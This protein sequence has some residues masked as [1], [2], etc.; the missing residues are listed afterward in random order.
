MITIYIILITIIYS[1]NICI[2]TDNQP[3]VYGATCLDIL[4]LVLQDSAY[5]YKIIY[6]IMNAVKWKL[7]HNR[8]KIKVNM[9]SS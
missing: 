7:K 8:Y 6:S 5:W 4:Y 1:S 2:S 9:I 3:R